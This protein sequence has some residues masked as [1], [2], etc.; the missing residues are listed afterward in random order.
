MPNYSIG[1]KEM[2]LLNYMYFFF[3]RKEWLQQALSSIVADD[4][5]ARMKTCLLVL[6]KP[7]IDDTDEDIVVEK[8][9][10]FEELEML[11]EPIDNARGGYLCRT[12]VK[13]YFMTNRHMAA[14]SWSTVAR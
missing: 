4:D 11:V 7:D 5:V 13:V 10:A 2:H 9:S 3:Q 12:R 6:D 14:V 1:K 8:E